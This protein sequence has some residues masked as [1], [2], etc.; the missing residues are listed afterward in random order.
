MLE[1]TCRSLIGSSSV[2][3]L[4]AA[5]MVTF[6]ASPAHGQDDATRATARQLGTE[7]VEAYQNGD[8]ATA[9]KK[10]RQ[11]YAA[12]EAPTLGLW[13]ARALA[14]S[15]RWVE[16]AELYLQ[17]TQL[18]V[19][20]RQAEVQ[21]QAQ[22]DAASEREAL[23]PRIPS[24]QIEVEGG[25]PS[26]LHIEIDGRPIPGAL[27]GA[28]RPTD[29]GDHVL[30]ARLGA[31]IET[32]RVTLAEGSNHRV[33]FAFGEGAAGASAA[34]SSAPVV[35]GSHSSDINYRPGSTQ[36]TLGWT[37][38]AMGGSGLVIGGVAGLMAM[39]QKTTLEKQCPDSEC[40]PASHANVDKYDTTRLISS[41]GFIAGAL[42]T[43]AGL[44]LLLTAPRSQSS[45][46]KTLTPWL[47]L[48]SAGVR[49][50]F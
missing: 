16:A 18:N 12:L 7:G 6:L 48:G 5:L 20:G 40:P 30:T 33:E 24:L 37:S 47:G 9:L 34:P 46:Q 29:P 3:R 10:L 1:S 14:K 26:E 28:K 45:A 13:L 21:R 31:R 35:T 43:A 11:A 15:G 39:D 32:R 25:A 27:V 23:L 4:G 36:R 17:V 42:G 22:A 38:L 44:T 49:G 2:V 19:S 41:V 50:T 8:T